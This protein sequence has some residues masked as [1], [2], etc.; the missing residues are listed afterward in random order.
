MITRYRRSPHLI[1]YWSGNRMVFENY[2]TC[3][4]VFAAPLLFELL[5]FFDT[6]RGARAFARRF[7][8]FDSAVLQSGL[9]VLVRHGLL[10]RSGRPH[11]SAAPRS[12]AAWANWNPAAGLLHFSTKDLQYSS[13]LEFLLQRQQA[14]A[15]TQPMPAP[16]K[17]YPKAP[18]VAPPCAATH[19][20]I[21]PSPPCSPHLAEVFFTPR[22]PLRSFHPLGTFLRGAVVGGYPRAGPAGAKNVSFRRRTTPHRNL[23]AGSSRGQPAAR[24]LSLRG[25][26]T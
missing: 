19:R 9:S 20:R 25:G 11:D 13:D 12:M 17:H 23:R 18:K 24:S 3:S 6:W 14:R 26:Q 15:K 21:S 4:K 5:N 22:G 10:Q 8:Q 16:V 2:Y 7:P 1:F